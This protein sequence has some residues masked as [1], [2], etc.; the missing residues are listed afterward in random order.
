M[1]SETT[2]QAVHPR[3]QHSKCIK[4]T[5]QMVEM[6]RKTDRE[7]SLLQAAELSLQL[8]KCVTMSL[9]S[10]EKCVVTAGSCAH[11]SHRRQTNPLSY[12]SSHLSRLLSSHPSLHVF[13]F[14]LLLAQ[15]FI[16]S[17]CPVCLLLR[18]THTWTYTYTHTSFSTLEIMQSW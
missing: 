2:K 18:N 16:L 15:F 5:T 9:W 12:I 6:K 3:Q 7:E 11:R 14:S 8:Q 13:S 17:F 10:G 1:S 4:T